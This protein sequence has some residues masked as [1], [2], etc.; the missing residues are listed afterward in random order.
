MLPAG[1]TMGQSFHSA[2]VTFSSPIM[3]VFY[4]QDVAMP[5][6]NELTLKKIVK[7]S[8]CLSPREPRWQIEQPLTHLPRIGPHNHMDGCKITPLTV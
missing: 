2:L 1:L 6:R 5:I 8:K 7:P 3:W 4:A